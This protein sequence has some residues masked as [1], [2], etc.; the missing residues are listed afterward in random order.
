MRGGAVNIA[1][2]SGV[3]R[4]GPSSA[5]TDYIIGRNDIGTSAIAQA[6]V[7]VAGGIVTKC[8]RTIRS[9]S[10]ASGVA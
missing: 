7:D 4:V 3:T 2:P 1:D 8:S 5:D 9:V 10:V 6:D